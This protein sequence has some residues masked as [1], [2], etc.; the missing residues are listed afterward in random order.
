MTVELTIDKNVAR[1]YLNNP[2]KRNV[3]DAV[4]SAALSDSVAKAEATPSVNCL[5]I[6]AAG[7]SFCAG[8][9]LDEL[10]SAQ[11]QDPA[12]L[13]DIYAGFLAVANSALPT[14]CLVQGA[15]VGAG[16]NL[17]LACDL[18]LVTP[19][20]KFDTRFMQL[21]IHCGGGH[22]WMLQKFLN[23][24][25]SVAALVFGQILTGQQA[26]EKGLAYECL[27]P[28]MISARADELTAMLAT[29][30]RELVEVTK[31]SLAMS[32]ATI[33]HA[34]MVEHEYEVQAHSLKQPYAVEKLAKF[35]AMISAK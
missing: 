16:M 4:A 5:V 30:P 15:A 3:L 10:I 7:K 9:S 19:Y 11:Q 22:S 28:E 20:A 26:V 33:E 34:T 18:R 25:Q 1:I 27:E 8:G 21:G 31:Q 6:S 2:N 14:I 13:N 24:E 32:A 35:K 23:W 17:V 12:V 29:V